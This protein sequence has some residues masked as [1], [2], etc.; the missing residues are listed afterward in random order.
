MRMNLSGSLWNAKRVKHVL[1]R[2]IMCG[3]L[4]LLPSCGIPPFRLAEPGPGLPPSFNGKTSPENSAQLRIEEFF[5]DP[6]LLR[7]IDQALV[8]NRELRILNEDVQ[9]AKNEIL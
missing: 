2:A 1:A 6:L 9:I 7:L 3:M 4:L 5:N 8:G